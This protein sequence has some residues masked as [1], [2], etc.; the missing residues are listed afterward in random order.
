VFRP[1][2]FTSMKHSIFIILL[3]FLAACEPSGHE[4]LPLS[5]HERGIVLQQL[6]VYLDDRPENVSGDARFDTAHGAFYAELVKRN[7]ASIEQL[8][9]KGDTIYFMYKKRDRRSLYEH[10]RFMGG[11]MVMTRTAEIGYLDILFHTPRLSPEELDKG[12]FLFDKMLAGESLLAMHGDMKYIEW[13]DA[14][15]AYDAA[16]RKWVLRPGSKLNE[17]EYFREKKAD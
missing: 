12:Q 4:Q 14:D 3:G 1:F 2:I 10:Y 11:K 7:E 15:Y 9:A 5:E 16:L 17:V 6:A 8:V 13:P